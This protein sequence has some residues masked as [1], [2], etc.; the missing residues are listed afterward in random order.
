MKITREEYL[1][2]IENTSLPLSST[3]FLGLA[4]EFLDKVYFS[5]DEMIAMS[6][7]PSKG[8]Y[9]NGVKTV[10][11]NTLVYRSKIGLSTVQYVLGFGEKSELL[12][13]I[14]DFEDYI[15]SVTDNPAVQQV[16]NDV[17]PEI[18]KSV[19]R[20]FKDRDA[21]LAFEEENFN[22]DIEIQMQELAKT[23][24]VDAEGLNLKRGESHTEVVGKS[25]SGSNIMKT[26]IRLPFEVGS[27]VIWEGVRGVVSGYFVDE[28]RNGLT[29][30]TSMV[31]EYVSGREDF[32][33]YTVPNG[34]EFSHPQNIRGGARY[35]RVKV[36]EVKQFLL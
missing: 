2:G 16:L 32:K 28:I 31:I 14:D 27:P 1:N 34:S 30:E 5:F 23:L 36:S 35:L 4:K 29:P 15:N 33:D 25:K 17:I 22:D 12:N 11:I 3:A 13:S 21:I 26:V 20:L 9:E 10:L 6:N 19:E 8:D 18:R 7:R 24:D